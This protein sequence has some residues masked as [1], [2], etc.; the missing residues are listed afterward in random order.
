MF[1]RMHSKYTDIQQNFLKNK[2]K[3]HEI[4][5]ELLNFIS[6]KRPNNT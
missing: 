4:A 2:P 5:D 3:F 1:L 6:D